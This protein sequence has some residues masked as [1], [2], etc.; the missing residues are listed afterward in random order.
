MN[1]LLETDGNIRFIVKEFPIL[2]E[3]ST[4]ASQY[5]VAVMQVYGGDSYELIHDALMT[6]RSDVSVDILAQLSASFDLDFAAIAEM[7]QS[8]EVAD[9]LTQNAML[10]QRLQI[11][12][13]PTFIL[14]EEMLRGY[15]PLDQM[16]QFVDAV[17]EG[18]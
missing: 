11:T 8:K 4:L 17:R 10:A 3:Q 6:L 9:I 1:Q 2:G 12:G 18:S 15:V 13:T 16:L 5:A 7:M 14:E